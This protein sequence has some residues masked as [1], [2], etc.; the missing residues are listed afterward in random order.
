MVDSQKRVLTPVQQYEDLTER[1]DRLQKVVN[2]SR[3]AYE[4]LMSQLKERFGVESLEE[5]QELYDRLKSKLE[6]QVARFQNQLKEFEK[7][8]GHVLEELD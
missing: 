5:A 6:S 1:I 4:V 7:E 8:W 3:G 2:K